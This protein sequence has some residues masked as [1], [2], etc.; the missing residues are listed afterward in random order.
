M[1]RRLLVALLG[2][3]GLALAGCQPVDPKIVCLRYDADIK[4]VRERNGTAP[5]GLDLSEEVNWY[6]ARTTQDQWDD[7]DE[8]GREY[9]EKLN[10]IDPSDFC[11][12]LLKK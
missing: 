1:Q 2:I 8:I 7:Y 9:R 3:A 12:K 11:G 6:R 4:R 5:I 10:T